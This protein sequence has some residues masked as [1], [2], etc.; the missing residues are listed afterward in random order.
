MET[1]HLALETVKRIECIKY[2]PRKGM[3]G[4]KG[5]GA[6]PGSEESREWDDPPT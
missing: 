1:T 3:T 2:G 5:H 6:I 4:G